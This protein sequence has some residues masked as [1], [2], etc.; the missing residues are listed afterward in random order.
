MVRLN[1][2]RPRFNRI[3]YR[4]KAFASRLT[5]YQ[6]ASKAIKLHKCKPLGLPS[7]WHSAES[8]LK[9]RG[10]LHQLSSDK[11]LT[12]SRHLVII[13]WNNTQVHKV[14]RTEPRHNCAKQVLLPYPR[15]EEDHQGLNLEFGP[16]CLT[17][18][19][20]KTNNAGMKWTGVI[21]SLGERSC[22]ERGANTLIMEGLPAA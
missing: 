3:A 5:G 19:V 12:L 22:E 9:W 17:A 6:T 11:S 1:S 10:G 20:S 8:S 4:P 13:N 2:C 7:R 14:I 16:L 18:Q 15:A 21:M